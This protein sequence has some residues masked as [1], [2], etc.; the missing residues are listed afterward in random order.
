MQSNVDMEKK[1]LAFSIKYIIIDVHTVARFAYKNFNKS[2]S[3]F[4]T[5]GWQVGNYP[6]YAR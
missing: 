5:C 6:R 1:K 3:K 4:Q 2:W